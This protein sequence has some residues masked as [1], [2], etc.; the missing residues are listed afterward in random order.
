MNRPGDRAIFLSAYP[1]RKQV[2]HFGNNVGM[3]EL[4]RDYLQKG[5]LNRECFTFLDLSLFLAHR[6]KI[7]LDE[8]AYR[9]L[10]LIDG[11]GNATALAELVSDSIARNR[12]MYARFSSRGRADLA[13]YDC[14]EDR[15]FLVTLRDV[16]LRLYLDNRAA[17]AYGDHIYG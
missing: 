7:P 6:A 10:G 3:E 2:G 17:I 1:I 13:E 8:Q 5:N 16:L 11:K 15:S 12:A 9:D 14:F 4:Y